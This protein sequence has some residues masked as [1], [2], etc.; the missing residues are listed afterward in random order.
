MHSFYS[1]F[2]V[3]GYSL[4]SVYTFS[5]LCAPSLLSA[6]GHLLWSGAVCIAH[7]VYRGGNRCGEHSSWLLVGDWLCTCQERLDTIMERNSP[8][9]SLDQMPISRN[10]M[11]RMMRQH[12]EQQGLSPILMKTR[13]TIV[14]MKAS[15]GDNLGAE[16]SEGC[17]YVS[18]HKPCCRETKLL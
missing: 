18:I 12:I 6:V 13:T 11:L 10:A 9:Q 16:C 1:L 2:A 17:N 7:L 5:A 3:R 4:L 8:D 15:S 14:R